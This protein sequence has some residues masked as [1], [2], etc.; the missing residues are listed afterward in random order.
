MVPDD[1]RHLPSLAIRG[2]R[3]SRGW[4]IATLLGL[5]L[6]V[7]VRVDAQE[8]ATPPHWIWHPAADGS[9]SFPAETRYFRKVFHVKE[10]SRLA[11][12]VTADNAFTL[13]LDGKPVAEGENWETS[14]RVETK[15][16]TGSHVLAASAKNTDA[17]K[18]AAGFL[19]GGGVLPLG[20]GV[21]IHTNSSW[22]T[23]AAVPAGDGWKQVAFDDST[24]VAPV[25]LGQLG[26]AP[27]GKLTVGL[28]DPA[29]RFT[30]PEGF[31]VETAG[32]PQ[33][34]GSVVA[35][36]FDNNG[37]PCVSIERGPI[38]RLIDDDNDGRYDRRVTITP[39]MNNCQGLYFHK[40]L[41]YA[42]GDGPEG[43]GIY[44]L[45]DKDRDGVFEQTELI[46]GSEGGM[47]E[48]GPHSIY[49]GPDGKLYFTS[50]NHTHLKPPIDP[51]SPMNVLYEGELLPHYGD[52]RGHAVGIK[53]PG[54][55][56][57]RSDD[58]GKTWKRVVG[59][60][61]NEYDSAFNSQ[62]ELFTFDSDM[63]WD[64]GLPWYRP[65][66]VNHCP[67]GADL[68]WRTGSADWPEYYFD[69]LPATVDLGRGSPTGV[70]FYNASRFPEAYRDQFLICDWS[71]GRILAIK[72]DRDGASY[73]GKATE[74][75]T[76]QPLN[77]TDIETGPDGNV[78]FSTGGRATQGGFFRLKPT[79]A[80]EP[81]TTQGDFLVTALDI[82]SPLSSFSQHTLEKLH[83]AHPGEWGRRLNEVAGNGSGAHGVRHRVR[84]L[85]IM[86]QIGPAPT[87]KLLIALAADREPE[88]RSRAVGLL[89]FHTTDAARQALT[90]ALGDQD[91][92]V[93]RHACESLMQQ[94]AETIP[95][96]A[97]LPLLGE[98]DRFLRFSA[99]TAIEHAGPARHRDAIL[100]L[101]S[102]R[103]RIEGMLALV[104]TSQLDK[105]AQDDLL[106]QQLVLLRGP[107]G[108]DPQLDLLR[109]IQVTYLLGP[110]KREAAASR[111]FAL[112]LLGLYSDSVDTPV[113]REVGRLLAF[114][115]EP[116]A[117]QAILAH[118]DKVA[119]RPSQIHDAYCLRAI[120]SGW[121][122]DSKKRFWKWFEKASVWDGGYSFLGYL[123]NMIAELVA[124]LDADERAGLLAEGERYPF[125]TRVLARELNVEKDVKGIAPLAALYGRLVQKQAAGPQVDDL[126]SIIIE[127]LGRST[128]PEAHAAL[129]ALYGTDSGRHEQLVRAIA[130]HPKRDDLPILTKA[131]GS[132]DDNTLAMA[133]GA[134][135]YLDVAPDAPEPL[136]N[137]I[138]AARRATPQTQP[139]V[140]KLAARWTGKPASADSAPF[141]A[142][143]AAWEAA[144]KTRY[145]NGPSLAA[146][147]EAKTHNYD[148]PQL[149]K[150]VLQSGL[151]KSASPQ[152]GELV[153]ARI[154]CLDCHKFGDKGQ[155]LGPDLSTVNSRFQSADILD[156]IVAPSKVIS[157][158][159]K[160]VIVA[161]GDG[162]IVSGMPIV[163]DGP[164][165][166]LLLS[167]GSKVTIPKV[168]IDEQKPSPTSVMPE[169]L[170]NTLEYQDVA[171]LIAL[172]ES[173]PRVAAPAAAKP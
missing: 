140:R 97:L 73:R 109:L 36:T 172:F 162:R 34:T 119:D 69:S 33:V 102:P 167:D 155:G 150:N 42:V 160:T 51:A 125:P 70:T 163:T 30:T 67:I 159:Y 12:D 6:A 23:S 121:D 89:G 100:T 7:S 10:P 2:A 131:L 17:E 31:K 168:E 145:P 169:G 78:Y 68:G 37:A 135:I 18:G 118:Q 93:R 25:D 39:K 104:R 130:A 142:E 87:E 107:L 115:D 170:L 152:R 74:L 137:L 79:Q 46:R 54:G 38:A 165:L 24:W 98:S 65:V 83:A 49:L 35:F 43:A 106:D 94:P 4:R 149:V 15:I 75:V 1:V 76:G 105:S 53:A 114:L 146:D 5:L 173:I 123:D 108:S 103:A 129:Q 60:F 80:A 113:N 95:V 166:V 148:L 158:Q 136:A 9:K 86:S 72:L 111:E 40:D 52:P 59:G 82:D 138:R 161:T 153:L 58:S 99:R 112:R 63:E 132:R 62:G 122:R 156:S 56:I 28:G 20:Q 85:E 139:L 133:L 21:P 117:V 110:Q 92:F 61:R 171:D 77:C 151:M 45:A 16:E 90:A 3:R 126:K 13:Y 50:G 147:A 128:S 81:A 120:K 29:E 96:A 11:L 71:Q 19:I 91:D 127:T 124:L 41:L 157:D 22:K 66:R 164:N 101:G 116:K 64:I 141:P 57:S 88:V 48:H 8:G 143:L 44:R 134:L 55:E 27:W 26:V 14:V 144:Y 84:A 32:T 154:R 47:G